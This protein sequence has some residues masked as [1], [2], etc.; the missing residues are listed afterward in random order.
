MAAVRN[1]GFKQ[2][3]EKDTVYEVPKFCNDYE[4]ET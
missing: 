1:L 4:R 3:T 2:T